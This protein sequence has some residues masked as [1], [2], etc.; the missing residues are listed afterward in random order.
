VRKG[1]IAP[2]LAA[3]PASLMNL[4]FHYPAA[5]GERGKRKVL[6]Y[7][8]L[9]DR[10]Q[11]GDAYLHLISL[12]DRRDTSDLYSD[13]FRRS[14]N[15]TVPGGDQREI[16]ASLAPELNRILHLQFSHWLPEDILMKQDKMS[17]AGGIEAR[18]PFLDHEL[19]EYALKIPPALKIRGGVT[20]YL[21]RRYAA[22]VLPESV[23]KRRKMPFYVPLEKYFA[24][25]V[26]RDMVDDTL[27]EVSVRR[28]GFFR[29]DAVARLRQ[30][31]SR[32]EFVFV[33]QAFSLVVLELWCRMAIDRRGAE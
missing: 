26:F 16:V 20:K 4:A 23:V 6:D 21:L 3:T 8:G 2:A 25:P 9:L 17:M 10:E 27:S 28:R 1:L 29:P 30:A 33:K 19:V 5:L 14:V 7:L 32:N 15:G 22:R 11:L 18:V 31:M 24:E 12:F 13:D